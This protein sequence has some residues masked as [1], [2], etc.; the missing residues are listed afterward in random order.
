MSIGAVRKHAVSRALTA[1]LALV[2]CGGAVDW[3]HVG[4]DDPDCNVVVVAHDHAAHRLSVAPSRPSPVGDHCYL[5]H[6]LR[7]LHTAL[8]TRRERVVLSVQSVSVRVLAGVRP[9]G[10]FVVALSSRAP[11]TLT[12]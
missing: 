12:L 10:A 8:A 5:C 3:G 1:I 11:P 6:S 9:S 4:G 2:V 7:L